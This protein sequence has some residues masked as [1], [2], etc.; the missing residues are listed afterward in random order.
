MHLTNYSLFLVC[1]CS[2]ENRFLEFAFHIATNKLWQVFLSSQSF[3]AY[4]IKISYEIKAAVAS[5]VQARVPDKYIPSLA[6]CWLQLA[7]NKQQGTSQGK[8]DTGTFSTLLSRTRVEL[9]KVA[10]QKLIN[11]IESHFQWPTL[12][13]KV[14]GS[15]YGPDLLQKVW[16]EYLPTLCNSRQKGKSSTMENIP[17]ACHSQLASVRPSLDSAFWAQ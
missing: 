10:R 6:C 15:S 13:H 3:L 16:G 17:L 1:L 2:L 12:V 9:R 7:R 8:H 11:S 4:V 5:I 14:E